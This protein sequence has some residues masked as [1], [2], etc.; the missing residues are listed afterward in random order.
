MRRFTFHT[1]L[2][3]STVIV[4]FALLAIIAMSFFT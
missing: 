2:D 3:I 1:M 4:A